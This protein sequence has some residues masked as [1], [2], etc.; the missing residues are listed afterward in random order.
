MSWYQ[1]ANTDRLAKELAESIQKLMS[2]V[3][4]KKVVK[5]VLLPSENE[6]PKVLIGKIGD[7]SI[8]V[9]DGN[10]VKTKLGMDFVEGGNDL[11]YSSD[12]NLNNYKCRKENGKI[13]FSEDP[14]AGQDGFIPK[15]EIW[16]SSEVHI[17]FLP[18]ILYHEIVEATIM[19]VFD[20][21]Y[22]SSH[23]IANAHEK[24]ARESKIFG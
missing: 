16:L 22:S 6:I 18:Y 24:K 8:F 17:R 12:T 20:K 11:A 13:L 19:K 5:N 10:A 7:F 4:L 21:D 2:S 9:V 14:E 23:N 3:D 1:K 15:N